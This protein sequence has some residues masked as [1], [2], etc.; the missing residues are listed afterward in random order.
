M[1][2]GKEKQLPNNYL[3]AHVTTAQF[4]SRSQ[5]NLKTGIINNKFEKEI[6]K[7]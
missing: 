2:F 1:R 7:R 3:R 6:D 5:N 4:E